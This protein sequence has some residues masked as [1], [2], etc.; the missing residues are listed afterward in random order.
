MTAMVQAPNPCRAQSR[1]GSGMEAKWAY[2][3]RETIP[4]AHDL[5]HKC[6]LVPNGK[7]LIKVENLRELAMLV[8]KQTEVHCQRCQ[9]RCQAGLVDYLMRWYPTKDVLLYALNFVATNHS[10]PPCYF[11]L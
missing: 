10:L 1:Y 3:Y 5:L 4:K 9:Y 2:A 8:Q 6:L 7:R 11:K